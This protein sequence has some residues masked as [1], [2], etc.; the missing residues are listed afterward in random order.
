[1]PGITDPD[2]KDHT[3]R[4][5]L[6]HQCEYSSR[7]VAIKAVSGQLA[8][9]R[10][11]LCRWVHQYQI[12]HGAR[13]GHTTDENWNVAVLSS[14]GPRC[15]EITHR[16]LETSR[17]VNSMD[18][19]VSCRWFCGLRLPGEQDVLRQGGIVGR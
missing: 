3:L 19:G 16:V 13:Q 8:V 12:C 14:A 5:V 7:A 4:R 17:S 10:D 2:L 9:G 15:S 6:D 18:E 11:S 1:M